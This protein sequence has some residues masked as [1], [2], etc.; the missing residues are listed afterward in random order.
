MSSSQNPS[1]NVALTGFRGW[2]RRVAGLSRD[3][4]LYLLGGA[5]MGIGNG[6]SWVHLNL[7]Y[8]SL[9]LGEQTIGSLLSTAAIGATAI[10]IPSAVWIDRLPVGRVLAISAGGFAT[11]LALP[12]LWPQ[13]GFLF[14][15]SLALGALF[16]VH[17]VAAAPF[18]MRTAAPEDRADLFGLAHAIE[19]LATLVAALA[20]GAI[21]KAGHAWLGSER[22]GL[23]LG[24]GAAAL[25]TLGSVPVFAAIRCPASTEPIKP[26]RDQLKARDWTLLAKIVI[27]AGL[28]GLGAGLII[29]FMNLYFRDR[30]AL[31][32]GQIGTVFA[33]GQA[34]TTVGFLLGPAMARRF[35]SVAAIV[36]TELASIPFFLTLAFAHSLPMAVAAFWLRG[37]LMQMNQPITSA[38][39]MELVPQDQQAVTNSVR[40]LTWN[41]AWTLS[42]QVGG[43]WI[44][45]SGFVPPILAAVA[46][47]VCASSTFALFFARRS[48]AVAVH[49]A[50]LGPTQQESGHSEIQ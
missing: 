47:Y 44:E 27:P 6:A 37:A 24:L 42:T 7:W 31:D 25:V 45:K 29:P 3:A 16:T 32:P 35:G 5:L 8:K 14:A 15:V 46:F 11:C 1:Q 48:Q 21:A 26:W 10:A 50:P 36:T 43:W 4:K 40:H 19:T 13:L 22:Q 23:E 28:V 2:L 30:F 34:F 38:F 17:W 20:V 41:L 33:A 9:G 18:F 39:S 12:L 49:T